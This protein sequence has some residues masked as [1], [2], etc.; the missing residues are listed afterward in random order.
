MLTLYAIYLLPCG[1]HPRY[2]IYV[3]P[4]PLLLHQNSPHAHDPLTQWKLPSFF[5]LALFPIPT[6]DPRNLLLCPSFFCSTQAVGIL[7]NKLA[8]TLWESFV[9]QKLVCMTIHLS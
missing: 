3:L 5:L 6:S 8:I 9:Q 2:H 4:G 7:I 1:D